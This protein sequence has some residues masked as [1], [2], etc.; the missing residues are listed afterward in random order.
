MISLFYLIFFTK[1]LQREYTKDANENC[2]DPN[3]NFVDFLP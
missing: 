2:H 1:L 3:G